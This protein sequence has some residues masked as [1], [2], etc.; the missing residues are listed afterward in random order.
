MAVADSDGNVLIFD[1]GVNGK[2]IAIDA[3]E[4]QIKLKREAIQSHRKA[5]ALRLSILDGKINKSP[6]VPPAPLASSATMDPPEPLNKYGD[7]NKGNVASGSASRTIT[8]NIYNSIS[9]NSPFKPNYVVTL[10][11]S[12]E[13]FFTA[14]NLTLPSPSDPTSSHV[15]FSPGWFHGGVSFL[16]CFKR[17]GFFFI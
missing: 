1:A 5:E 13:I 8:Y 7:D 14:S 4:E 16:I 11:Y 3:L 17:K 9:A 2:M 12:P 15:Y 6:P 10:S